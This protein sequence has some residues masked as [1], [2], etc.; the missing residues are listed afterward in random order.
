MM[1]IYKTETIGF[2][3]GVARAVG[4]AE[5]IASEHRKGRVYTWGELI[6]NGSI[7]EGLRRKGV[8]V[9]EDISVVRPG[10]TVIIVPTVS[11]IPWR[12]HSV[13]QERK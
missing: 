1:R 11:L 7:T 13:P 9:T 8:F 12:P 5:K 6:H 2:C 4:M 3:Y 10:D